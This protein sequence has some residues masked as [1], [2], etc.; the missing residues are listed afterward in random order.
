MMQ[1]NG[2]V[3]AVKVINVSE[4]TAIVDTNHRL[5]GEDLTFEIELVEIE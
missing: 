1:N 4:T 3:F 2:S 5:A